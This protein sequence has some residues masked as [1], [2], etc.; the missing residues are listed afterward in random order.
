MTER[1]YCVRGRSFVIKSVNFPLCPSGLA[2][3][4]KEARKNTL[5][6]L[7]D[8][9]FRLNRK[10]VSLRPLRLCVENPILDKSEFVSNFVIESE[11]KS[12]PQEMVIEFRK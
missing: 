9:H 1:V 11:Y 5:L 2:L 12:R 6:R 8:P 3:Q 7:P 10:S 4:I